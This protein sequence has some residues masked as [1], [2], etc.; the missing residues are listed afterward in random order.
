MT[1]NWTS[2]WSSRYL[3]VFPKVFAGR[4]TGHPAVE[5]Q[6]AKRV[7]LEAAGVSAY[8]D[9]ERIAERPVEVEVVPGG[10]RVLA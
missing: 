9:G 2:S 3:A 8:A 10:L 1:A 7:R 5:I 6:R 4:H